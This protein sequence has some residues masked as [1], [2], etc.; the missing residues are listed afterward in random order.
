MKIE[1]QITEKLKADFNP[2]H[3]QV[4]NESHMHNVP[5]GSESHFK[6]V[7]V[8]EV[9]EGKRLIQRHKAI[10]ACLASELKNDIH[11]L[12]MHTYTKQEWAEVEDAPQ[13]P[14]CLGGSKLG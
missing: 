5:A 4:I 8:S 12:A 1:N 3:L 6:V 10:N 14:K 7:V 2:S 9:F 13:S 11:A